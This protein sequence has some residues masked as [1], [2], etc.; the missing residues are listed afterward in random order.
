[1]QKSKQKVTKIVSLE[2]IDENLPSVAFP[3]F[4]VNTV[5]SRYLELAYLE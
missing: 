3:M 4:R 5:D 2:K 1:M